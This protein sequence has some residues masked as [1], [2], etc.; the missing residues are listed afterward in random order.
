MAFHA[1]LGQ[2][3]A[4]IIQDICPMLKKVC[5]AGEALCGVKGSTI[6]RE[7][8]QQFINVLW[9]KDFS[10]LLLFMICVIF[11][12]G[13]VI[14]IM[15][16]PASDTKTD[17][18]DDKK[19]RRWNKVVVDMKAR[20]KKISG[21]F[22]K[23]FFK[24][25]D[26]PHATLVVKYLRSFDFVIPADDVTLNGDKGDRAPDNFIT[27]NKTPDDS[28]PD[29]LDED[30][31]PSFHVAWGYAVGC[32]RGCKNL[33]NAKLYR[34]LSKLVS[35]ATLRQEKWEDVLKNASEV[36]GREYFHQGSSY[37]AVYLLRYLKACGFRI[38]DDDMLLESCGTLD[39]V[40]IPEKVCDT[41]FA[42]SRPKDARHVWDYAKGCLR[43]ITKCSPDSELFRLLC[44]MSE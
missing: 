3:V 2:N 8:E 12:A 32:L 19:R 43:Y 1:A 30:E 39:I 13:V 20:S 44:E 4:P 18:K 24:K 9:K 15:L 42:P 26:I 37:H 22:A 16:Y 11:A 6:F 23:D 17:P 14:L 27:V 7:H 25:G 31:L 35:S 29:Y 38:P 28:L 34:H 33:G 40:N 21:G 36:T 5:D 41:C 10:I